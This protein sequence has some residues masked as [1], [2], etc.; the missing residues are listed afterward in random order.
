[1]IKLNNL[2]SILELLTG[3][4]FWEIVNPSL[5]DYSGSFSDKKG[6]KTMEQIVLMTE[7]HAGVLFRS[8]LVN[9]VIYYEVYYYAH[10]N[11][12]NKQVI[13]NGQKPL[14]DVTLISLLI[15]FLPLSSDIQEVVDKEPILVQ[16]PVLVMLQNY[17]INKTKQC[18]LQD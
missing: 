7:Q 4:G 3:L 8:D 12:A 6:D 10:G 11:I 15:E 14:T 1:M 16:N 2:D 9:N 17:L 5:G 13:F 18:T